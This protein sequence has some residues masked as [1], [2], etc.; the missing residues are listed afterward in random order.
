MNRLLWALVIALAV[1]L[2][3]WAGVAS[4]Q[5]KDA[6]DAS[7]DVGK[8]VEDSSC[9]KLAIQSLR[10]AVDPG[11]VDRQDWNLKAAQAYRQLA[12]LGQSC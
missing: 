7:Q 6:P 1:S 12:D 2:A 5:T 8:R 9:A 10:D 11:Q 3:A 4:A